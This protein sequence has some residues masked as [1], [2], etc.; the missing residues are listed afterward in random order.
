MKAYILDK[1]GV[2]LIGNK[3]YQP[4][5]G[6]SYNAY[7]KWHLSKLQTDKVFRVKQNNL[8]TARKL[9]QNFREKE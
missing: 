4:V 6:I 9:L 2:V 1:Q 8:N 7:A 3:A 5:T